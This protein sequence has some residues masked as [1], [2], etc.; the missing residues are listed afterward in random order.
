MDALLNVLADLG[1]I[2]T[3]TFITREQFEKLSQKSRS[4]ILNL[5]VV[6]QD[7]G[8]TP[9]ERVMSDYRAKYGQTARAQALTARERMIDRSDDN[10]RAV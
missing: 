7:S 10:V 4:H 6:V 5:G 3:I 8:P 2:K 9:Y 1:V